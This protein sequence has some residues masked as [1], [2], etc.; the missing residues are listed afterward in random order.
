MSAKNNIYVLREFIV[1]IKII[2]LPS[3]NICGAMVTDCVNLME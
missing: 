3:N 1:V 2:Y